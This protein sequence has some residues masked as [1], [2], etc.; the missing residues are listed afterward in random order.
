[1]WPLGTPDPQQ[2]HCVCLSV[3]SSWSSS[4]L[5]IS[6]QVI[7]IAQYYLQRLRL[8]MDIAGTTAMV[9]G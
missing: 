5:K 7:C 9:P 1:M 8:V 3:C 4:K 6:I 2:K